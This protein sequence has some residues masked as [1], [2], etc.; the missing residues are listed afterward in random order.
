MPPKVA[1]VCDRCGGAV[2][3]RVDDRADVVATRLETYRAQTAPLI[4]YFSERGLLRSVDASVAADAVERNVLGIV[5][6]LGPAA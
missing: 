1:D 5:E 6:A 4:G 3:Q 2:I